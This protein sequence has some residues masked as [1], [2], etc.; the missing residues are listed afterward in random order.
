MPVARETFV[1]EP[2]RNRQCGI[3]QKT[4][5]LSPQALRTQKAVP[6]HFPFGRRGVS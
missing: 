2:V 4:D 5:E 6:T 3:S 1:L